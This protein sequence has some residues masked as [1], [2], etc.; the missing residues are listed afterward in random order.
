MTKNITPNDEQVLLNE[1]SQLI[2]QSQ[3]KL[4]AQ[5]NSTLT[6]LFWHIGNRIN[7]EILKNK[8]A[9]YGEQIVSSL[10]TQLR[11]QYG[12]NFDEKNY[13]Y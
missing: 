5:A 3:Q 8:R 6:L 7:K 12:R 9:G 1:L 11:T 13:K 10:S 4:V 2:E